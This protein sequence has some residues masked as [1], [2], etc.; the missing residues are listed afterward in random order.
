M[1]VRILVLSQ[2]FW[3]ENFR[4]N[5]L[6]V[7]L[8]RRGHRVTVLT[9][10]PNY[11]QGTVPPAFRARPAAF[12]RL[13]QVEILR[14]PMLTRGQGRIRLALNYLSFA[15]SACGFGLWALRGRAF[16]LVFVFQV[17]P[18]TVGLPAVLLSRCKRARLFFW[19][20]DLWPETLEAIGAVRAPALLGLVGG[21]MRWVYRH[22]THLLAQSRAFV[23]LLRQRAPLTVAV[24]YLPNWADRLAAPGDEARATPGGP[25]FDIFYLGNLGAAQDLPTVLDAIEALAPD[26]VRWHFVGTGSAA[27]WLA[28]EVDRRGLHAVVTLHGAHPPEDM[29]HFQRQADA[30]LVCLRP[31]PLFA[32]TVPSKVA[33]YLGAGRPIIG[34]LDGEGARVIEA[35]GAGV[36]CPAGDS[37]ALTAAVRRLRALPAPA[38]DAMGEAGRRFCAQE[39]SLPGIVDQLEALFEA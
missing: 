25:G 13:E 24:S 7:E 2:Y 1:S 27:A 12:A 28:Q 31:D 14:V 39:F 20:Q 30:L 8:A 5:D 36:T 9:G 16:D 17:S 15:L 22:S 29:P 18:G 35:A 34:M 4:I 3:P 38:R 11:P 33:S 32:L 37:A 6:A 19:V 21:F 26:A 10:T 23:P